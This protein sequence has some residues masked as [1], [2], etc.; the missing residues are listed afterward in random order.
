MTSAWHFVAVIVA[1]LCLGGLTLCLFIGSWTAIDR[2]RDRRHY[3]ERVDTDP[4]TR[5]TR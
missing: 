4:R 3:S 2:R 5:R 1:T